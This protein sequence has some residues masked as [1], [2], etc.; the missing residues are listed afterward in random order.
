[1]VRTYLGK[2]WDVI[3]PSRFRLIEWPIW[4]AAREGGG[5]YA[6]LREPRR[7]YATRDEAMRVAV[8]AVETAI[9]T[10][11]KRHG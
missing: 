10:V 11:A 4:V 3:S 1:M 7:V 5:W 2:Q 9:E 8:A 6:Y